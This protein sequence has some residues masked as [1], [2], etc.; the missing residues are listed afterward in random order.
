[1]NKSST[2]MRKMLIF[3]LVNS[4]KYARKFQHAR[5]IPRA[6]YRICN[7]HKY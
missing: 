2:I 1:M 7:I 3:K 4:I 6:A 5:Y